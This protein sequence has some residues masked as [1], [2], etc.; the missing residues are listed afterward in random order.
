M[1]ETVASLQEKYVD[2][3]A[4]NQAVA[5]VYQFYSAW[6]DHKATSKRLL[7]LF[8]PNGFVLDLTVG[9]IDSPE[10]LTAM[11]GEVNAKFEKTSHHLLNLEV[12][13]GAKESDRLVQVHIVGQ[14]VEKSGTMTVLNLRSEVQCGPDAS[15]AWK[16]RHYKVRPI[17]S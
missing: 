17:E 8:D 4:K 5:L 6:E 11:W 14:L 1:T 7:D 15:G 2:T 10:K 12:K 3:F 16:V 9:L 13:P